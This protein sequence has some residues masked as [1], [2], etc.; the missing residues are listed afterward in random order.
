MDIAAVR[1]HV[2]LYE[3]LIS[4]SNEVIE[5]LKHM[6]NGHPCELTEEYFIGLDNLSQEDKDYFKVKKVKHHDRNS[7]G[8][9]IVT[10][11]KS[12]ERDRETI[13]ARVTDSTG[14]IRPVNFKHIRLL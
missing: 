7:T 5:T 2:A 14:N 12:H 3:S 8:L 9:M 6:V 1:N 11:L 10:V 13:I 4:S